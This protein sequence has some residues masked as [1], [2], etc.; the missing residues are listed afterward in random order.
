MVTS[1][2]QAVGERVR[3]TEFSQRRVR[4]WS[5]WFQE[6]REEVVMVGYALCADPTNNGRSPSLNGIPCGTP[7]VLD[8]FL[9][10]P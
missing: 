4:A 7:L 6:E 2:E 3:L 10:L 9:N 1:L 5:D 8:P